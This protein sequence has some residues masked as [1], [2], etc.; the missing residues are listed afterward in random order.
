MTTEGVKPE[1]GGS[2]TLKILKYPDLAV[3]ENVPLIVPTDRNT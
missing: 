2:L 3:A 1:N